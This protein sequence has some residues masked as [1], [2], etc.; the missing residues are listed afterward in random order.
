MVKQ[1][2]WMIC[3]ALHKMHVLAA[4]KKHS[5]VRACFQF[6]LNEA[7]CSAHVLCDLF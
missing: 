3:N 1:V 5:N 7:T 2:T 6:A 4:P